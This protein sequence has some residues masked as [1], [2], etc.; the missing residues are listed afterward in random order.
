M[1]PAQR[2]ALVCRLA[3]LAAAGTAVWV[4][5]RREWIPLLFLAWGAFFLLFLGGRFQ[6]AHLFDQARH[7][8]ARRAVTADDEALAVPIPCCSFWRHSGGAVH[9]PD[10]TRPPEARYV[11]RNGR[12]L[13]EVETAAFDAITTSL[14][15][16]GQD[17]RGTA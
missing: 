9:G 11:M 2:S 7:D 15:Q 13:D 12:P 5:A 16:P 1:T 3:A 4:G 8:R 17:A 10:C 6:S 14:D